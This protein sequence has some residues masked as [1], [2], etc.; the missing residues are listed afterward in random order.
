MKWYE[1]GTDLENGP[2]ARSKILNCVDCFAVKLGMWT[3]TEL[4]SK[5]AL[6]LTLGYRRWWQ[7]VWSTASA[8]RPS[9]TKVHSPLASNKWIPIE[10]FLYVLYILDLLNL[11][12]EMCEHNCEWMLTGPADMSQ[13]PCLHWATVT[14]TI[15]PNCR[16]SGVAP[17]GCFAVVL[18]VNTWT[19]ATYELIASNKNQEP[20]PTR[21]Q[22]IS[23]FSSSAHRRTK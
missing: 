15:D 3:L 14:P 13:N 17:R 1:T 2:C 10:M 5:S 20:P 23:R 9:F 18:N 16:W 7:I 19:Q 11:R 8:C 22:D 21:L 4:S 6:Q 12:A